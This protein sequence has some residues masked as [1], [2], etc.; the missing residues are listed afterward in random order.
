MEYEKE[1]RAKTQNKTYTG[2]SY[3]E[4]PLYRWPLNNMSLT[5][6]GPLIHELF[7]MVNTTVLQK[8]GLMNLC[9][10]SHCYGGTL[11]MKELLYR[12]ETIN[13]TD[14]QLH[15]V[16]VVLTPHIVQL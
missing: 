4:E 15:R 16:L 1:T 5:C 2:D 13:Y 14:F 12:E 8:L 10:W 6:V 11:D 7:S 9:M 3:M